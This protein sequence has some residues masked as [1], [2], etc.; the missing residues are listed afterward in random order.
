MYKY[1]K[2][3]LYIFSQVPILIYFMTKK[4]IFFNNI[5]IKHFES[6]SKFNLYCFTNLKGFTFFFNTK[7]IYQQAV[8]GII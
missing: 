4:Q 5:F 1:L 2:V 3:A 8:V 7:I 6:V